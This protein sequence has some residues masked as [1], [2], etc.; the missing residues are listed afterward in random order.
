MLLP[1]VYRS[2]K[3]TETNIA[4]G[5]KTVFIIQM[6]TVIFYCFKL[7]DRGLMSNWIHIVTWLDLHIRLSKLSG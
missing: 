5:K 3:F 2:L 4:S 7:I 1:T 6:L